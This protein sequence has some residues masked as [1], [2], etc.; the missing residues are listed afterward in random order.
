MATVNSLWSI[1]P[2]E[3]LSF[4]FIEWQLRHVS[5]SDAAVSINTL[6]L[7]PK[8]SNLQIILNYL[9]QSCW[10]LCISIIIYYY[11]LLYVIIVYC[12]LKWN[13]MPCKAQFVIELAPEFQ[14]KITIPRSKWNSLHYFIFL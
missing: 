11:I 14:L 10:C 8:F 2:K 7:D 1:S 5:D 13:T 3:N 6:F 9:D 4:Q 12:S